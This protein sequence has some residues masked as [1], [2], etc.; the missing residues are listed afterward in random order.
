MRYFNMK[1]KKLAKLLFIIWWISYIFFDVIYQI[2][3]SGIST[4][5][6]QFE[7]S[8]PIALAVIFYFLPLQLVVR[9]YAN[10]GKLKKI[11]VISKFIILIMILWIFAFAIS[12]IIF[13]L[14]AYI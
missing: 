13:N 1:N 6:K 10:L 5:E 9:H 2:T 8:Y 14:R 11:E 4:A 3:Q 7:K 12:F